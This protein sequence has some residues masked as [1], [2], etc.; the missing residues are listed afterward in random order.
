MIYY[1]VFIIS[2]IP[3]GILSENKLVLKYIINNIINL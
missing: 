2:I 1:I 3:N